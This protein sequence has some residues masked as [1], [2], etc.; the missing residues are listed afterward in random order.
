MMCILHI[1][2]IDTS[3]KERIATWMVRKLQSSCCPQS[4]RPQWHWHLWRR[5][6]GRISNRAVAAYRMTGCFSW[7][8]P[9]SA[10]RRNPALLWPCHYLSVVCL[11]RPVNYGSCPPLTIWAIYLLLYL[12][13]FRCLSSYWW[14]QKYI[15]LPPMMNKYY[16]FAIFGFLP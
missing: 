14:M 8:S 4:S 7:S 1:L 15:V 11:T 13:E 10:L 3:W 5:R 12:L 2:V 9:F 6:F 16:W